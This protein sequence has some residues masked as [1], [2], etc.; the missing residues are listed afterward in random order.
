MAED[1]KLDVIKRFQEQ[2]GKLNDALSKQSF[3]LYRIESLTK[4]MSD[5][6][7]LLDV[8]NINPKTTNPK[9][10]PYDNA[11]L[12]RSYLSTK[13]ELDKRKTS[14]DMSRVEVKL[15]MEELN[16]INKEF[17]SLNEEESQPEPGEE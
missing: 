8:R 9:D 15:A 7:S 12:L 10:L 17:E 16:K 14:L 5:M 2:S 13:A 6:R 1:K 11:L 4:S 3:N